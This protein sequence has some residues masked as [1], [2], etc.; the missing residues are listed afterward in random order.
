MTLDVNTIIS[1][2]EKIKKN[3]NPK[4]DMNDR[5]GVYNGV[6]GD[7]DGRIEGDCSSFVYTVLIKAGA[8]NTTGYIGNTVTLPKMLEANGFELVPANKAGDYTIKRGDVFIWSGDKTFSTGGAIAHTGFVY[9]DN[10]K[11]IHLNY[12]YD[13]VSINDHDTIWKANGCPYV[14]FYRLSQTPKKS[15]D[16]VANEVIA[17][18]WGSGTD[19]VNRLNVAGYDA[20]TIQDIVNLKLAVKTAPEYY[21]VLK[22]DCLSGIA[23]K[24]KTTVQ[25]LQ[26]VNNLANPDRLSIGQKLRIK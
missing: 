13:S 1:E 6:D 5:L 26:K 3:L 19:R 4:Y 16:T 20:K 8:V 24:Y 12:G 18:L 11:I 15:D 10:E 23:V 21:V 7:R 9:D 14:R 17:G 25:A 22:G 2:A